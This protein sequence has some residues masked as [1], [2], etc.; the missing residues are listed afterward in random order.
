MLI[1][2][3]GNDAT[4]KTQ[5][6]KHLEADYGF[7]YY[8]FGPPDKHP[9]DE[10]GSLIE[11]YTPGAGT[12]VVMD[13]LH[14]G[15]LVYAPHYRGRS[16][17]GYPGFE[18]MERAIQAR[19]GVTVLAEGEPEKILERV[20]ALE[21]D[22]VEKN[23]E[24][25]QMLS[26]LYTDTWKRARTPVYRHNFDAG[27]E[28]NLNVV[29]AMARNLERE[30]IHID[31]EYLGSL[32][33][34]VLFVGDVHGLGDSD[35]DLF[36][37]AAYDSHGCGF[38][39]IET[40]LEIPALEEYGIINAHT[41]DR[42]LPRSSLMSTWERLGKPRVV[43]LGTNASNVLTEKGIAH[44]VTY[45]PAYVK[46]FKFG[47]QKTYANSIWNAVLSLNDTTAMFT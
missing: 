36:P 9:I 43:A 26:D 4:G 5:L 14:W 47:E 15:E 24:H 10:W 38:Y 41:A 32:G 39:L 31:R 3:E 30:A 22:Y 23:L 13:R 20:I 42:G 33:A 46:R 7:D 21:D 17:L 11:Q 44:G 19:G 16:Q 34:T 37:F 28:V 35:I 27:W 29:F 40:L 1:I 18:W 25:L 2:L 6:A 8:H 12:D 45:H